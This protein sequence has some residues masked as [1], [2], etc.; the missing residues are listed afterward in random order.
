MLGF[1]Q[2][3]TWY[4]SENSG[5][6]SNARQHPHLRQSAARVQVSSGVPMLAQGAA[7]GAASAECWD[8]HLVSR[9]FQ[10]LVLWRSRFFAKGQNVV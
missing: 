10:A 4:L 1:T 9:F 5:P 8:R 7:Q 2:H 6:G 3:D